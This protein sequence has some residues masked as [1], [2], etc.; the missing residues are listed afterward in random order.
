MKKYRIKKEAVP[1]ILEKYATKVLSLDA[2]E[3]LGIDKNALDLVEPA[4][5][6][7]GKKMGEN[8][9]S[10]GGWSADNGAHFEFTIHFPSIKFME[11]DKFSK[12]RN[13]RDLM[14]RIQYAINDFYDKFI[15]DSA[16]PQS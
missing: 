8:S 6:T 4:F 1:F 14:D 16:P 11:N 5:I 7:Y 2:W 10:L 12:G 9:S 13:T 3:S 15:D